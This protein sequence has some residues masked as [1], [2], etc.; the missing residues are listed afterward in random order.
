MPD[1]QVQTVEAPQVAA[2]PS[3]E[4][5]I[6]GLKGEARDHWQLHGNL[7]EAEK[8]NGT[9]SEA[10]ASTETPGAP[11]EADVAQTEARIL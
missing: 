11:A 3:L 10:P 2:E 7:A 8:L 4:Q 1:E 9:R 6:G 5:R